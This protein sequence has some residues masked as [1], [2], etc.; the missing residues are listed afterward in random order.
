MHHPNSEEEA[1]WRDAEQGGQP[2][3][4]RA[5][6]LKSNAPAVPI[7]AEREHETFGVEEASMR[8]LVFRVLAGVVRDHV[9]CGWNVS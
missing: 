6:F 9:R 5:G 2:E 8:T 4:G 1:I 3:R 7:A